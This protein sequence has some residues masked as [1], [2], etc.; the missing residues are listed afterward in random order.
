MTKLS[1]IKQ[2]FR[3]PLVRWYLKDI[4]KPTNAVATPRA[5]G[6]RGRSQA[7]S[8]CSPTV[9]STSDGAA[10]TLGGHLPNCVAL[11]NNDPSISDAVIITALHTLPFCCHA[12]LVTMTRPQLLSVTQ[13]LNERLPQA[14]RIDTSTRRTDAFIRNSIE[15]LVGIHASSREVPGAPKA[16]RSMNLS[17]SLLLDGYISPG[18]SARDL[19]LL[20]PPMSPISPLASRSRNIEA[21]FS[22]KLGSPTGKPLDVLK[23]EVESEEEDEDVENIIGKMNVDKPVKRRR[24]LDRET[25]FNTPPDECAALGRSHSHRVP[26]TTRN[27]LNLRPGASVY[28]SQSQKLPERRRGLLAGGSRRNITLTRGRSSSRSNG[29]ASTAPF[30]S[31]DF[32]FNFNPPAQTSTPKKRKR[33]PSDSEMDISSPAL[34]PSTSSPDRM[35]ESSAIRAAMPSPYLPSPYSTPRLAAKVEGSKLI[36]DASDSAVD[37]SEVTFRIDGLTVGC[38]E[39][40]LGS[41]AHADVGCD[42]EVKDAESSY[43]GSDMDISVDL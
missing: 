4:F 3:T 43:S 37:T 17:S 30:A 7:S 19:L 41:G 8:P 9:F 15:L 38:S 18:R 14:L 32:G 35:L 5:L 25:L 21:D 39:T 10:L 26:L 42:V 2:P 11:Q 12:D 6:K 23:E 33:V 40:S 36:L 31:H 28:R 20:D 16:E 29:S 27:R 13:I 34:S 22:S 24:M 1:Y